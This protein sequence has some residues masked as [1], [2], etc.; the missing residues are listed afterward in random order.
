MAS[1]QTFPQAD[2]TKQSPAKKPS[3]ALLVAFCLGAAYVSSTSTGPRVYTAAATPAANDIAPNEAAT[4]VA[5][6]SNET[7]TIA[8]FPHPVALDVEDS[9][10]RPGRA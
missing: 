3:I 1:Y 4:N 8:E 5:P 2:E 9:K 7:C 6:A 10:H